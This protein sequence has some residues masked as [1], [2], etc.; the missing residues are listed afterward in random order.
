MIIPIT[1]W[2]LSPGLKMVFLQNAQRKLRRYLI[3]SKSRQKKKTAVIAVGRKAYISALGFVWWTNSSFLSP[4]CLYL[5]S[6]SG[7]KTNIGREK[8]GIRCH[9]SFCPHSHLY[10]SNYPEWASHMITNHMTAGETEVG[11]RLRQWLLY[12]L[13][14]HFPPY[15]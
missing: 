10:L 14:D 5:T 13:Y 4:F 2:E 9:S 1:K 8:M 11:G 3:R 6:T 12:F 15:G 7:V